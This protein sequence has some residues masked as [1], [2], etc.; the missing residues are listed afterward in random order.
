M[1]VSWNGATEVEAWEIYGGRG[2]GSRS[3]AQDGTKLSHLATIPKKGFESSAFI[4]DES[5]EM[6]QVRPVMKK[7]RGG[8]WASS[9]KRGKKK[10]EEDWDCECQEVLSELI[11]V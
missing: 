4:D 5:I 1:Y 2:M 10:Y 8:K 7:R 9:N 6:V 3:H 11:T